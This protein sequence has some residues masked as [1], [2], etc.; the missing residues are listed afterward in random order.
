MK[1]LIVSDTHRKNDNY[2]KVVDMHKPDMVVHCGD[3]EGSEYALL[4]AV[5][6]PVYMVCGNNDFFSE[7]PGEVEFNVGKYKCM[8]THG[9]RYYVSM[10]TERLFAEARDRGLDVI[11]YGHT[12]KPEIKREGNIYVVNPGSL[13]YPRQEGRKPSY[14]IMELDR[15]EELHFTI[16]YL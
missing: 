16:A 2:F 14:M 11:M 5:S 9:H 12:H 10:G 1:V 13:S 7:L 3:I 15:F 4:N 8:A 6:C